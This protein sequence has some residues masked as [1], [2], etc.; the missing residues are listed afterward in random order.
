MRNK[1]AAGGLAIVVGFLLATNPVVVNAA[2]QITGAQ[3]KNNSVASKDIKN[4]TR[5]ER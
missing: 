1:L 3:I 2:G 5:Q 4:N